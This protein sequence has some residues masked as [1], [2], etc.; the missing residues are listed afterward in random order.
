MRS[1]GARGALAASSR[2]PRSH[3]SIGARS[4]ISVLFMDIRDSGMLNDLYGSV[5]PVVTWHGGHANKFIG[6]GMRAVFGAPVPHADHADR[7]VAAALDI[8][9]AVEARFGDELRVGVGVNSGPAL[10]GT[11]GGGGRLDF[12]VIGDTVN[13][14]ARVEAATRDTG[15]TIL[16][17]GA[18]KRRLNGDHGGWAARGELPLKGKEEL[19]AVFGSTDGEGW[20]GAT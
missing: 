2:S 16:I 14:A 18:T 20:S 9:A 19:V 3:A 8:A 7:A 6:D 15:D 13:T 11:V 4:D 12:T 17:T 1:G 5:V 10:A